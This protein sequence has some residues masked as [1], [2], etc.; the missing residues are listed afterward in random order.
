M[1]I[2]QLGQYLF[3]KTNTAIR[4]HKRVLPYEHKRDYAINCKRGSTRIQRVTCRDAHY[5][6]YNAIHFPAVT[7]A[8][9]VTLEALSLSRDAQA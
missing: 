5:T 6:G 9:S 4:K 3:R 8:A 2:R 7:V 1:I